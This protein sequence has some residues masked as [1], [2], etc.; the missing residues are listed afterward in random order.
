MSEPAFSCHLQQSTNNQRFLEDEI[1]M[2][3]SL[4]PPP[5]NKAYLTP[6]SSTKY[7]NNSSMELPIST[8]S[9]SEW[10]CRAKDAN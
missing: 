1:W 3:P 5:N 9:S 10:K 6:A 7:T 8:V 4:D 2:P